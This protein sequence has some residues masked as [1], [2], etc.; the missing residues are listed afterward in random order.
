MPLNT[1]SSGSRGEKMNRNRNLLNKN[2]CFSKLFRSVCLL[3]VCL[4]GLFIQSTLAQDRVIPNQPVTRTIDAGDTKAFTIQL[5][6]GDF[7]SFSID[8]QG[9]INLL[10]LRPDGSVMR[11]T[12]TPMAEGKRKI[13]YTAEGSGTYTIKI[14]ALPDKPAK[15]ELAV[16][17]LLS[18]DERFRTKPWVD[19][20]PSPRIQALRHDIESGHTNTDA[21]WKQITAEGTPLFEPFGNSKKFE[22]VTF[23]WRQQ[24]DIRNVLVFG[25]FQGPK[26]WLDNTMHRIPNSDVWYLTLKLPAGA[27]FTYKLSPNDPLTEDDPG[28]SLDNAVRAAT[29]QADSFNPHRVGCPEGGSVYACNSVGESPM[30]IPQPWFGEKTGVAQGILEKQTFKSEIQKLERGFSVYTPVGYTTQSGPY[31][32]ALFF[33]EPTYLRWDY[34]AQKTLDNLIAAHK[35]PPTVAVF[36]ANVADRR[37]KDLLVN[38]EFADS[39]A[40]ELIPWVRSHYNVTKNPAQ[41][42]VVGYSAGG[43]AAAYMGL[44]HSE[45]F[46]NV[47]SQSGSFWWAPDHYPDPDATTETNW[48]SKQFA[49][50][51]K[52]PVRFY[53]EAGTFELD[54]NGT[55]GEILV[56][57]RQFRDVLM[58]RGYDVHY[59]QF[60]GGH[61]GVSWRGT[62]AD[63]LIIF[64]GQS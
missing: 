55:G 14:S 20:N 30:A 11:R 46:G 54:T 62:L 49:T 13:A 51:P 53:L 50:G 33:D 40:T 31:P 21:F 12:R 43:L 35:I 9:P 57:S 16:D 28:N 39:I 63:G 27:R 7:A 38:Q 45:I 41:T 26:T 8:L 36:V 4:C 52:L 29:Q 3:T 10:I 37:L 18:L 19:P 47:L 60:V 22:L 59:Y 25:S 56:C 61:D 23:L 24:R 1:A 32:L 6:D 64:L 2:G 15:I 42:V 34:L 58:A 17:K 48:M 5:T 44:R